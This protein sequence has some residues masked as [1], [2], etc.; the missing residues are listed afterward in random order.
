M[1]WFSPQRI[2][3]KPHGF[4]LIEL[5]VV[6]SIIA[7]LSS[8]VLAMIPQVKMEARR[9]ASLNNLRGLGAALYAYANDNDNK[10]PNRVKTEGLDKWPGLLLPYVGGSTKVYGE[11]DDTNCFLR[12]GADPLDSAAKNVTSYILNGFN[13]LGAYSNE[14]V[15]IRISNIGQPTR[16]ILMAN[17]SGTGNYYMD[18]VEGNQNS[19]LNLKAYGTGSNYLF[20]DGSARFVR[21]KDYDNDLWLVDKSTGIPAQN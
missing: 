2:Q 17:Q 3:K 13:D 15:D 8:L 6:I 16:T 7:I 11:P 14:A 10:I 18:F 21:E 5:L 12:T 19:V 9:T 20:A 1:K 4:T